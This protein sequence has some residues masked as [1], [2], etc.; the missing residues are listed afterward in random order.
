MASATPSWM[1]DSTSAVEADELRL[2]AVLAEEAPDEHGVAGGD[3]D[4]GEVGQVGEAADGAGEAER[5]SREAELRGL[6]RVGRG[7]DEEVATGDADV[8]RP[9]SHVR[10][11]VARAEV[12]EL[13]VV[14][15]VEDVELLGVT[16]A[17]VPGLGEHLGGGL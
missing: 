16:P 4:P 11:D 15:R 17:G 5:G 10:R 12:E 13:D 14:A 8:E 3:A 7:V 6:G 1:A 9:G 2:D